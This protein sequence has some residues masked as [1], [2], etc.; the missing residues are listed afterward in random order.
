[1]EKLGIFFHFSAFYRSIIWCWHLLPDTIP[2]KCLNAGF[3]QFGAYSMFWM[4][5]KYWINYHSTLVPKCF[6]WDS[7]DT[8][9]VFFPFRFT[10]CFSII[11]WAK[12]LFR[13]LC[14]LCWHRTFTEETGHSRKKNPAPF[15]SFPVCTATRCALHSSITASQYPS[16][17]YF[18]WKSW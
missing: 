14:A 8:K 6:T 4:E 2:L 13:W 11:L 1:V 16:F 10:I 5:F 17:K 12:D 3:K 7:T 9:A 15:E 18:L